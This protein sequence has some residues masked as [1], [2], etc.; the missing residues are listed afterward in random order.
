MATYLEKYIGP[1]TVV[2]SNNIPNQGLVIVPSLSN[3]NYKF[4]PGLL[5]TNIQV[6]LD[7]QINVYWNG[8]QVQSSTYKLK[9]EKGPKP[10]IAVNSGPVS[11]NMVYIMSELVSRSVTDINK[12]ALASAGGGAC[13]N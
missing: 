7:M 9:K 8:N 6:N 12:T 1:V 4:P 5:T 13:C 11:E 3:F 10:F 2:N